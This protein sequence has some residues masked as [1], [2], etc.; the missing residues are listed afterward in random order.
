[1]TTQRDTSRWTDNPFR[2][3]DTP[4]EQVKLIEQRHREIR[5]MGRKLREDSQRKA[6]REKAKEL[7][8]D[9]KSLNE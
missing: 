7:L 4:P 1:M 3:P 6:G 8:E 5:E 9:V 2:S